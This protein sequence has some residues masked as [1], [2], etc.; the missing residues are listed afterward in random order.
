VGFRTRIPLTRDEVD[1][2]VQLLSMERVNRFDYP[3]AVTEQELFEECSLGVL[4]ARQSTNYRGHRQFTFGPEDSAE[5]VGLLCE[6]DHLDAPVLTGSCMTHVVMSRPYRTPFTM[7]LTFIGHWPIISLFTV[8]WRAIKKRF[9]HVD[10]I[11]TIG[12]LQDLHIGVLADAME[13]ASVIASNGRC[14]A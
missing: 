3:T 5:I 11:P 7:L 4:S 14:R 12:Y 10:D 2:A 8:F 1:E 6:L 13:R 9:W